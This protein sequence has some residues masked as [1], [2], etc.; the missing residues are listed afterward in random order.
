MIPDLGC[1]RTCRTVAWA[2]RVVTGG[3]GSNG[4][5]QAVLTQ[6]VVWGTMGAIYLSYTGYALPTMV[7]GPRTRCCKL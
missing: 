1:I 2:D 7:R 5:V 3:G 4:V 6:S